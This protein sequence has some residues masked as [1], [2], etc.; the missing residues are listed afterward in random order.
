MSTVY[1]NQS[2]KVS[3]RRERRGAQRAVRRWGRA[4]WLLGGLALLAGLGLL[5]PRAAR[6]AE[7]GAAR[8]VFLGAFQ[9]GRAGDPVPHEGLSRGVLRGLEL[10]VEPHRQPRRPLPSETRGCRTLECLVQFASDNEADRLLLADATLLTPALSTVRVVLFDARSQKTVDTTVR[11]ESCDDERLVQ[12][13]SAEV[14]RFVEQYP[15]GATIDNGV[16]PR[17]P[18]VLGPDSAELGACRSALQTCEKNQGSGRSQATRRFLTGGFG[19]LLLVGAITTVT[20][21]ALA[22]SGNQLCVLPVDNTQRTCT[23]AARMAVTSGAL[24]L[25]PAIGLTIT[26]ALPNGK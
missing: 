9:P 25:I 11:C 14:R 7:P 17:S 21:A 18:E 3:S 13:V 16:R 20:F 10:L 8:L 12:T 1:V 23:T 22:G 2:T 15:A 26:L 24:S 19:A 4:A 5:T 6:A